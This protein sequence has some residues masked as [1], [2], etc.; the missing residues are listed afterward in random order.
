MFLQV[1]AEM[2]D[3]QVD[4]AQQILVVVAVQALKLQVVHLMA[5]MVGQV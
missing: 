4:P 2:L 5:V 1:V 3:K